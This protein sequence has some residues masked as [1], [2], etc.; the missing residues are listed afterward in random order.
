M[1]HLED[2]LRNLLRRREP[3][4]GFAEGVMARLDTTPRRQTLAERL[5]AL[6]R[7]PVVRWAAAAAVCALVVLGVVRHEHQQRARAQAERASQEAIVALRITNKEIDAA[8][9]RAQHVTLR[10]LEVPRNPKSEM[11]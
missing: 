11:E 2:E 6:F 8:L 4:A 9:E 5:S 1:K 7:A 10:A 3:P